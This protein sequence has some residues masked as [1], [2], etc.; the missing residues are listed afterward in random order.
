MNEPITGDAS[1]RGA[2]GTQTF[3]VRQGQIKRVVPVARLY[4][5]FHDAKIRGERFEVLSGE[6]FVDLR[7]V[8]RAPRGTRRVIRLVTH[9][10]CVDVVEGTEVAAV[11]GTRLVADDLL[12]V[13]LSKI[14]KKLLTGYPV[15]PSD[16]LSALKEKVGDKDILGLETEIKAALIGDLRKWASV[17]GVNYSK[18]KKADMQRLV[19]AAVQRFMKKRNRT[20]R[21]RKVDSPGFWLL[22]LVEAWVLGLFWADGHCNLYG[23]GKVSWFISN[24]NQGY[25]EKAKFAMEL[26]YPDI[27]FEIVKGEDPAKPQHKQINL[28][29][30]VVDSSRNMSDAVLQMVIKYRSIV[31]QTFALGEV[32]RL[33]AEIINNTEA[34]HEAFM[35]GYAAGDLTKERTVSFEINGTIGAAGW[36]LISRSMGNTVTVN[37]HRKHDHPE[38]DQK[39]YCLTL[40]LSGRQLLD[41]GQLKKAIILHDAIVCE[42]KDNEHVYSLSTSEGCCSYGAHGAGVRVAQ[43][44]HHQEAGY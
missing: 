42:N 18:T 17:L 19:I 15:F 38:L 39:N 29:R 8:E 4:Q 41:P 7:D 13:D 14:D 6:K 35:T 22:L 9:T 11:D 25:L 31:Y 24:T 21:L 26:V 44:E 16:E 5:E 43:A 36:F 28:L 27:E 10:G 34:F 3:I 23:N 32:K 33:P 37:T 20:I 2:V 40:P 12:D 1:L 30:P